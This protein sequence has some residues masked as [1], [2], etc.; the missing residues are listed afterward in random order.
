MRLLLLSVF[1]VFSCSNSEHAE[2]NPVDQHTEKTDSASLKNSETGSIEQQN[3]NNS[4]DDCVFDTSTFKF[5]IEA[6]QKFNKNISY[7]WDDKEK[8][9]IV[10]LENGDTLILH[11]GGCNHFS[12]CA[13]FKTDSSVF[14]DKTFLFNKAEWL[15]KNFF[16]NGFDEGFVYYIR[17]KKYQ[18]E[19]DD[20]EM[21][22]YSIVTDSITTEIDV[23]DGFSIEMDANRAK[24]EIIGYT[25]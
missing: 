5:T 12:Y 25:N 21:R 20:N 6:L 19:R 4:S 10:P 17:N 14:H 11:I 18:L 13:T 23:Y 1:V 8:Q 2:K 24:I 7:I 3:S 15:A 16:T 9:A 22:V